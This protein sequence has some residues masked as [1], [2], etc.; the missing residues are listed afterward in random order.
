M[1]N[2]VQIKE[3]INQAGERLTPQRIEILK[4][5]RSVTCHPT[6]EIIYTE[7]KKNIPTI[8][9]G[10]IYRNLIYLV[11]KGYIIQ[12]QNNDNITCYDGN[13]KDHI[14]F[15]CQKCNK[16]HD[17]FE[18]PTIDKAKFDKLGIINKVEYKVFGVCTECNQ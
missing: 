9:L 11:T 10:T 16:V 6:A 3:K 2:T 7:V 15:I 8:S 4:Y 1:L 13:P 14:H 18:T 12:F 17:I 5:L